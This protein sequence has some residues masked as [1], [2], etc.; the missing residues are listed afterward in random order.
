[1]AV[2]MCMHVCVCRGGGCRAQFVN[3]QMASV[4]FHLVERDT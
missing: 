3:E 1:M 2:A 4:G